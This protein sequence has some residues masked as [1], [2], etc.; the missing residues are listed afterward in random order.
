MIAGGYALF[1][2]TN[3]KPALAPL[4]DAIP[5]WTM[6]RPVHDAIGAVH[7]ISKQGRAT[8]TSIEAKAIAKEQREQKILLED[9]RNIQIKR[10]DIN[11][12]P[13]KRR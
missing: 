8:I 3:D 1:R 10:D 2:G 11:P 6:M 13:L 9:I 7:D 4:S 5:A 12:L